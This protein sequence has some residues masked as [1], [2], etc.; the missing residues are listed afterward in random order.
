MNKVIIVLFIFSL[1]NLFSWG[2][3]ITED[4][5]VDWEKTNTAQTIKKRFGAVPMIEDGLEVKIREDG[6]KDIFITSK[7]DLELIEVYEESHPFKPVAIFNISEDSIID[8]QF[9][10]KIKKSGYITV[11][12]KDRNGTLYIAKIWAEQCQWDC[13]G[14]A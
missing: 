8:Y 3:V 9:T 2:G 11:I 14:E 10:L 7:L 12:G 1:T 4:R 6:G 13:E 5:E